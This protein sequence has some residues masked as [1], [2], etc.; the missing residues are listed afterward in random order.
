LITRRG[1]ASVGVP[2]G[3]A[4]VD[5]GADASDNIDGDITNTI[6]VTN[7]VNT[8]LV[9]AYTVTYNVT[10]FAG[11]RAQ[12]VTRTVNVTPAAG[13]GGGG[14]GLIGPWAVLILL[15]TIA[16]RCCLL[17]GGTRFRSHTVNR[18]K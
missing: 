7:P 2:A 18:R 12:P 15:L 10:D 9:G 13:T 14:G 5:Q 6:V 11:N 3:S 17:A 4:Y 8:N 16:G 1:Q